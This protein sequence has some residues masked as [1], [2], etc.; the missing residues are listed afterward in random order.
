M[1]QEQQDTVLTQR[2]REVLALVGRG[3]HVMLGKEGAVSFTFEGQG[4]DQVDEIPNL[5]A[6]TVIQESIQE[7]EELS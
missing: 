1:A 5:T 7:W 6:R 3:L 2:E 4:Y